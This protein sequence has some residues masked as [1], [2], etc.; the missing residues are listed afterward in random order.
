MASVSSCLCNLVFNWDN[1]NGESEKELLFVQGI[2]AVAHFPESSLCETTILRVI[3]RNP[4]IKL[5]A[6]HFKKLLFW[7]MSIV[8][9]LCITYIF[10][11]QFVTLYGRVSLV[12]KVVGLCTWNG[13]LKDPKELVCPPNGMIW[14]FQPETGQLTDSQCH[15]YNDFFLVFCLVYSSS[16]I[17]RYFSHLRLE[18]LRKCKKLSSALCVGAHSTR[19]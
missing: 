15:C 4:F 16:L 7:L 14:Y 9:K 5:K 8:K 13:T 17:F 2:M 1:N 18:S 19:P 12:K 3:N 11:I 6:L 10:L